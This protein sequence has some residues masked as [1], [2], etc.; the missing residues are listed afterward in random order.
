M[1]P[2]VAD[3]G[4]QKKYKSNNRLR[5]IIDKAIEKRWDEQCAE[6]EKHKRQGKMDLLLVDLWLVSAVYVTATWLGVC[7]TPVLYQNG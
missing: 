7:H 5:R 1:Q 2:D 6:L 3:T 4:M